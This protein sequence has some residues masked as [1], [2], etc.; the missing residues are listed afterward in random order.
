LVGVK[1]ALVPLGLLAAL[2]AS[3]PVAL[4]A[5]TYLLLEIGSQTRTASYY[6]GGGTSSLLFR[7]SVQSSDAR[8]GLLEQGTS[9]DVARGLGSHT[10][11]NSAAHKV[12]GSTAGVPVVSDVQIKSR[13]ASGSTYAL[14]ELIDVEVSFDRDVQVRGIPRLALTIGSQTRQATRNNFDGIRLAFRYQVQASDVDADGI[15]IGANALTLNGGTITTLDGSANAMLD[16][17]SHAIANDAVHKVNG[18]LATAPSIG[19]VR[20][21]ST[22]SDTTYTRGE[23]I[24]VEVS[25]DRRIVVTGT[26]QLALTIG[27]QTRQASYYGRSGVSTGAPRMYFSYYV[28]ASDMDSDGLSIGANALT[29]NGGT[30]TLQGSST[31]NANLGLGSHAISNNANHRVDGS[32]GTGVTGVSIAAPASGDSTFKVDEQVDVT[33]TFSGPVDVTNSWSQALPYLLLEIGSQTRA[34]SYF[35]GDGTSSWLFRYS[36]QSSDAD[37][38]GISIAADALC[39]TG[40]VLVSGTSTNAAVGLGSHA[41]ANSAAHKVD[42]SMEDAPVVSDVQI[43]TRPASGSTYALGEFINAEVLFDRPVQ[44]TGK[45]VLALTIGSQTR[46]ADLRTQGTW[47]SFR[48]YVQAS[49]VDADGLSI[50]ANALTLNGGTITA[51]NGSANAVLDLGSHAIAND[52]VHKVN[53]ALATAPSIARIWFVESVDNDSTYTLGDEIAF[54]VIWDRSVIVTGT[55]QLALTI[56]AQTRQAS[57]YSGTG[58]QYTRYRYYVQASDV[59][60]D[61]LSI[62][63]NALT[64]NGGT[65]TLLGSST[66]NANLDHHAIPDSATHKVDGG[67]TDS[68]F[69]MEYEFELEENMGGPLP[70]GEMSAKSLLGA[71]VR[72]ALRSGG[73]GLF[74]VDVLRGTVTY[75]GVGEDYE[76]SAGKWEVEATATDLRRT[77]RVKATVVVVDVNEAPAFADSAYVLELAENVAGPVILGTVEA[78]DVDRGDVLAYSLSAGDA[79]RFEVDAVTGE[80]RYVGDGEDAVAGPASY[81]LEVVATDREG[82]EAHAAVT[83]AVMDVNEAPAFA[84]DRYEWEIEENVTGPVVLG[85]VEASDPDRADTLTYSLAGPGA[86]R[87]E[88]NAVTGEVRYVGDGEDA[89][90]GPERYE[91][92]VVATDGEELETHAAATVAVLDVNEAPAFADSAHA[93]DLAEN[94]AGPLVLGNVEATDVDRGDMLAYSLAEGDAVRFEV[95]A[96]T[97]AVRYVGTGED[98]E[99]GPPTFALV[100]RA[101]DSGGLTAEAGAVVTLLDVNEGPEAVGAMSPKTLEA[102]GAAAEEDLGQYFRDPDGDALTYAAESSSPEVAQVAVSGSGRLSIAPQAI[103]QALVTVRATDPGGL[104][105]TQQVQVTVD[106]S[107]SERSRALKLTLAAFGRS[108]GTETVEAIGGRLGLGSSGLLGRSH[109]QVGGRSLSCA[110]FGG[111][112]GADVDGTEVADAA[113][114]SGQCGLESLVRDAS[115]LLGLQLAIPGSGFGPASPASMDLTTLL[116]GDDRGVGGALAGQHGFGVGVGS[117]QGQQ[118]VAA[119]RSERSSLTLNPVDGRSLRSQSS[120]Q[121]SFGDADPNADGSAVSSQVVYR[122]GWTIWGQANL[123]E[124]E[125]R[126]DDGFAMDGRTRSAYVGLDYRF[127]SGFLLGL[128]GS[129][130]DMAANFDS[131]INGAGT[132]DARLTSL[133]PYVHW[134]SRGGFGIWGLAGAGR[135][136]AT[137]AETAAGASFDT[138][139]EMRMGALGVRQELTGALALKADAFTVSIVSDDV[140]DMAGVTANAQ[141]VR[142]APE[143]GGRWSLGGGMA[144]RV[145]VEVGGRFDGGDA[146]TGM[147]AEAGAELGIAHQGGFSMTAR[148]RALLVHE[149]QDFRDWG[150]GLSLRMQS[151]GGESESGLSFSVEPSWG[152]ASGGA[153]MLWQGADMWRSARPSGFRGTTSPGS[154][155]VAATSG[156]PRTMPGWVPDRLAMEVGYGIAL[157]NDAQVK[158]FGRWSRE[159]PAG[160]RVNVGTRWAFLGGETAGERLPP[161]QGLRL[162]MDLFGE[163]VA[164]GL[165]P[166]ER[167]VGLLGRIT[168]DQ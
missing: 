41:I 140:A 102:H 78:T 99:Q 129:R 46:Q 65:I 19:G 97:G 146:E 31:T 152:D 168:F 165:Q 9:T 142:L 134:S 60:T 124:F 115:G 45:P 94:V 3:A 15:S 56:G 13:P 149:E 39:C 154:A 162:A 86:A 26:P 105:A 57:Y 43:T 77:A 75:V 12:D 61:G 62:G 67:H 8:A 42:G 64:L 17:G 91:F 118:E 104:W 69:D 66:T 106:A 92:E 112:S 7:Y 132:V 83:V 167:R 111:G 163:H 119:E 113:A 145:R 116:F 158:P 126:P 155:A 103:G 88:V 123:S 85:L 95:D 36:V 101:T 28:Q 25:W 100:L 58:S 6:Y 80:V 21:V 47:L 23:E 76:T 32:I 153:Q 82:L 138:D 40:K 156:L 120:F 1:T 84:A 114:T 5:Q 33:V 63:A 107:R 109:V 164:T 151:A 128:A 108:L 35:S 34:A 136:D 71:E 137:L 30:I 48:Y 50:G 147:G 51:S 135:G 18:A 139:L 38:D 44:V 159:G 117:Y 54:T 16:L 24:D 73:E 98:Y 29:L 127:G 2:G 37:A 166:P 55:P 87:F 52:A 121:L 14:G 70:V 11:A 20:I 141:R 96:A 74:G 161:A 130:S 68:A 125:G 53:G 89:E 49:D 160:H 93:F 150:A 72:Y 59:D 131:R 143:V 110:A 157:P 22:V 144:M 4:D 122:S 133:Y 90:T 27:A 148:G 81:E 10:I 79:E